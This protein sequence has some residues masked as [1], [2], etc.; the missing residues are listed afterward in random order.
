MFTRR[1]RRHRTPGLDRERRKDRR[2]TYR[3]SLAISLGIG[4]DHQDVFETTVAEFQLDP[5][6][7]GLTVNEA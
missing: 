7:L 6:Y 5:P 2:R 3:K 1:K 4:K